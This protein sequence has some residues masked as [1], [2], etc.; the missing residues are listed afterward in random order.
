M[1]QY[2]YAYKQRCRQEPWGLRAESSHRGGHPEYRRTPPPHWGLQHLR[3]LTHTWNCSSSSISTHPWT[4]WLWRVQKLEMLGKK[5][6]N[7]RHPVPTHLPATLPPGISHSGPFL[8]TPPP[9]PLT[10]LPL[11]LPSPLTPRFT[12]LQMS[13]SLWLPELALVP[14]AV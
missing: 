9:C 12:G 1:G 4:H 10:S 13:F 7:I 14:T 5:K 2:Q 6:K 3:L 11:L 8:V